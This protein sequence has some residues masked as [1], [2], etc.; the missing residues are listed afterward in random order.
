MN[1]CPSCNRENPSGGWFCQR[2]MDASNARLYGKTALDTMN[3]HGPLSSPTI[4]AIPTS[5]PVAA[6]IAERGKVYGDPQLSHENIGL[7]WTGLIQQH[8]GMKLE[9][10]LP[11]WLVN[12]MM[13][14]FK[15]NRSARVYQADNF[16]DAKAYL[17]FAEEGQKK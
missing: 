6:T 12:L 16:I 13:V 7:Q 11:A 5:D 2:C 1:P 9:H 3:T 10:P 4:A 17:Q 14:A 15:T 8:Y